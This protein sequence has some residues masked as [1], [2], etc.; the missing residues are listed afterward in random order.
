L[1]SIRNAAAAQ[2]GQPSLTT[3][4][5]TV[6][7]GDCSGTKVIGSQCAGITTTQQNKARNDAMYELIAVMR[8]LEAIGAMMKHLVTYNPCDR[9]NDELAAEMAW[10]ELQEARQEGGGPTF[11]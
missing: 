10:Q 4:S 8:R 11:H 5:R 7:T 2:H 3:K 1:Q 6:A 9:F